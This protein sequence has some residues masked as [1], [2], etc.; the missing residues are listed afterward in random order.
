M[1]FRRTEGVVQPILSSV[2]ESIK[3]LLEN[4]EKDNLLAV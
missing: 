1:A 3:L 2:T 4:H